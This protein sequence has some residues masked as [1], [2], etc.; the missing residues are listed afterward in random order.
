MFYEVLLKSHIRVP[1][2]LFGEDTKE[3]VLKSLNERFENY[4]SKEFGV[5]IGVSEVAEIGEG[6]IVAGDGAAYYDTTF[7]ILVYKPELQEVVACKVNEISDFGAFV[8]IGPLDGMIHISQTMDDFVSFSKSN[9]L[10]GKE[11]KRSLKVGDNC[12]ARIIAVSYKDMSNP[13]IGLTM[14]QPGLGKD[15]WIREV[16]K[17]KVEKKESK[18]KK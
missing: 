2:A 11:S 7:K 13:K 3:A 17:E 4:I 6:I 9:T 16:K 8:D 14:R 1:P 10:T 5:V 12:K 15:D 18:E